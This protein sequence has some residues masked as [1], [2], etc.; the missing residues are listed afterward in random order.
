MQAGESGIEY[1]EGGVWKREYHTPL[2]IVIQ[3]LDESGVWCIATARP[4]RIKP[5]TRKWR[6]RKS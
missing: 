1:K 4:V 6:G 3:T 2:G 5:K